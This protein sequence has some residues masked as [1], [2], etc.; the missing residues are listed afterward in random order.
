[1]CYFL[2][3]ASF[4]QD[5]FVS[6]WNCDHCG[7]DLLLTLHQ[8]FVPVSPLMLIQ[9]KPPCFQPS[10][11]YLCTCLCLVDSM[12]AS[13]IFSFH[14]FVPFV[15][16]DARA[17]WSTIKS[18]NEMQNKDGKKKLLRCGSILIWLHF[19][20]PLTPWLNNLFSH[21]FSSALG[22]EMKWHIDQ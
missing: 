15:K 17:V 12:R 22:I 20:W 4:C 5:S 16:P 10:V 3:S 2:P 13:S 6:E 21:V 18:A 19:D 7:N 9:T 8:K 14:A 1:M 11:W